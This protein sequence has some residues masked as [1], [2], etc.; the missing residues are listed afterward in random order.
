MNRKERKQLDKRE[1]SAR[2][3]A[4]VFP[5]KFPEEYAA[6]NKV[7]NRGTLGGK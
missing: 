1:R 4:K 7:F 3:A 5:Y 2:K 6:Y